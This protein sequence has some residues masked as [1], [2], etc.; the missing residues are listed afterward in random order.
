[1]TTQRRDYECKVGGVFPKEDPRDIPDPAMV[2]SLAAQYPE[3]PHWMISA[4]M[5]FHNKNPHYA[6][7]GILGKK[8]L[9]GKEKRAK[10]RTEVEQTKPFT[11]APEWFGETPDTHVPLSQEEIKEIINDSNKPLVSSETV[12]KP[13]VSDVEKIEEIVSKV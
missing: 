2:E 9:T 11:V 8:M 5:L 10:K 3:L 13:F 6:D 4:A 7:T 1:M 12:C